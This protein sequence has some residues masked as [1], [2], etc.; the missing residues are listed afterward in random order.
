MNDVY[1][2]LGLAVLG[3]AIVLYFMNKEQ[4]RKEKAADDQFELTMKSHG[5]S[6]EIEERPV[7][8][9]AEVAVMEQQKQEIEVR[10]QNFDLED[11]GKVKRIK[12]A[13]SKKKKSSK[14]KSNK[15]RK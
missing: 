2:G 8:M 12:K 6:M 13:P 9:H 14:K 11:L 5:L 4:K 15:R 7:M 1:L 10:D 3:A